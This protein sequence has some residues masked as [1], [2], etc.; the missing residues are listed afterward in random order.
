MESTI[1]HKK[2][3]KKYFSTQ[4]TNPDI[5]FNPNSKT[6]KI[7]LTFSLINC[8]SNAVYHLNAKFLEDDEIFK[9]EMKKTTGKLITFNSRYITNYFFEKEQSLKIEII[10]N[11]K[12]FPELNT[13]LG[14]IVGST[15][16]TFQSPIQN[17]KKS[18]S[19]RI[20]AEII[21]Q[22]NLAAFDIFFDDK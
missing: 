8:T 12:K 18:E 9:T 5:E 6:E 13:S 7:S 2:T 22:N 19:I 4:K 20:K 1:V 14:C 11:G 16:S 15:N 10:K 21:D 17:T 3:G